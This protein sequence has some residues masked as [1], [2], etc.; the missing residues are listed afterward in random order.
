MPEEQAVCPHC[1]APLSGGDTTC[2]NCGQVVASSVFCPECGTK[3]GPTGRCLQCGY[4]AAP[5]PSPAVAPTATPAAT[6]TPTEATPT[7]SSAEFCEVCGHKLQAEAKEL[8][9]SCQCFYARGTNFCEVCGQKLTPVAA[10]SACDARAATTTED[11]APDDELTSLARRAIWWASAG[12][13]DRALTDLGSVLDR[14]PQDTNARRW[15]AHCYLSLGHIA[16]AW[17]QYEYL[18]ALDP[19]DQCA[20]DALVQIDP[21][22]AAVA[23]DRAGRA[24]GRALS[25]PEVQASP[26]GDVQQLE[27]WHYEWP[28]DREMLNYWAQNQA[29]T[30]AVAETLRAVEA[31]QTQRELLLGC[32]RVGPDQFPQ[33]HDVANRAAWILQMPLPE[34]YV[35]PDQTWNAM[36]LDAGR[37]FVILHSGLVDNMTPEELLFI[38]GHEMAH[39]KSRH[40]LYTAVGRELVH[41]QYNRARTVSSIGSGLIGI[42]TGIAGAVMKAQA[43]RLAVEWLTWR[44]N[45]ELT[46]DRAGLLACGDVDVAARASA[47]L[48]LESTTLSDQLNIGALLRQYDDAQAQE[49]VA[50]VDPSEELENSHP[51][52]CYRIRMLQAWSMTSQYKSLAALISARVSGSA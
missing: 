20:A 19:S 12:E 7:A 41:R 47:K 37:T 4:C 15:A 30:A 8:C 48:M 6:G 13:F 27:P 46:C 25:W 36:A 38:L 45:K 52:T 1:Q 16:D 23:A 14:S 9:P 40:T 28:A 11:G 35:K 32:V 31:P 42:A 39:I 44:P 22:R 51:Y 18:L 3:L 2:W 26:W 5:Q 43:D 49:L 24:F 34:V 33:I 29:M 10:C 17:Q 50:A 21:Y